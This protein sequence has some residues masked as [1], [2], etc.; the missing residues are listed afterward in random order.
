MYYPYVFSAIY[1]IVLIAVCVKIILD[2]T[3][4]SKGLAYLVLVIS[5]PLVGIIIYLNIG[6]NYRKRKLYQKKIDVDNK[7]FPEIEENRI[8]YYRKVIKNSEEKLGSYAPLLKLLKSKGVVSKNNKVSLLLN[9]ENKFPEVIKCLKEAKHHIHLEYYIFENDTI[10]NQLADVLIEKVK[11]GVKVRFIYDDF[12]SRRIRKNL[13][14][15]LQKAGVETVPFYKIK[16]IR[17]ANRLNYRDHRKIIVIDGV[18]GFV[19]GINVA[20]NYINQTKNELYWRD[21]HL[22]IVG[23]AVMNLQ[24]TF[25]ASWNFCSEQNIAFSESYF[26]VNSTPKSYGNQL[27]QIKA[28]GPDSDYPSI[29]YSLIQ[30]ILLAKKELLI[31]TPYFIPHVSFLDAVKIAALSGVKVKLLVPNVGDSFIVN[32]TSQSFYQGMLEAGVEVYLYNKGFVHAKTM[33]CDEL[34]SVVGTANLDNRSFDLNF[35]INA[36]VYDTK[37]ASELKIAFDNDL[38]D[39]QLLVLENWKNRPIKEKFI[40]RIFYLFSSLM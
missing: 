21:T 3:T 29:L 38:K 13:V 14:R 40:E 20:D 27:V 11:E 30:I 26:P 2:T 8:S 7:L 36:V 17:L 18:T 5:F 9:G 1:L 19:G 10:G 32:T 16:F 25:L 28:S 31:T 33:V 23:D 6:L 24:F 12:G 37:I 34:I 39:S 35:E 22:K 15:K 4:P